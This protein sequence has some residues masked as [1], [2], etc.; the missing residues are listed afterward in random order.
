VLGFVTGVAE[1]LIRGVPLMPEDVER[2][3][4]S[5]E[6]VAHRPWPVPER[7]WLLA[8]SWHDTLFAH[9]PV[10]SEQL[11]EVVPKAI[12]LDTF[13]GQAWI[14][15]TPFVVTSFRVR[16]IPP[17]PHF[18]TFPELNVRTYA[19][20]GGRPGIYFLSLD[21]DSHIAVAGA[22]RS[23]RIPYFRADM[24]ANQSH[25]WVSYES[26]RISHDGPAAEF[27][28]AYRH[29]SNSFEAVPGSLEHW[30][31]ER[32][33]LYT[34]DEEQNVL[35]GEIHHRPWPLREAEADIELNTM[36]EPY[37]IALEGEPLV[38]Y[39]ARQDTLMWGLA[40]V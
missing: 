26:E 36:A 35:R 9:W 1:S 21:A 39:S 28:A 37:G 31:T 30:L 23:H 2:Q 40:P 19:T 5:L 18:S 33:C 29:A 38:H 32:Y 24:S 25:G 6:L 8:Q 12:P 4:M 34:I 27:R 3:Q 22:R 13:D 16:G 17:L 11:R 10:A 14:G 7:P 15:V 20:L